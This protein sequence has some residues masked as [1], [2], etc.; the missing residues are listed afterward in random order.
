MQKIKVYEI[1]I[2]IVV[3][4]FVQVILVRTMKREGLIRARLIGAGKATGDVSRH[5]TS[6]YLITIK[7]FSE[8]CHRIMS[9][10]LTT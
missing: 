4:F 5:N 2:Y 7:H 8:I 9:K 3:Y 1:Y 10:N 6:I